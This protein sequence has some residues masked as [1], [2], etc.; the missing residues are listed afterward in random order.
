MGVW[1]EVNKAN[2]I[3]REKRPAGEKEIE[4]EEGES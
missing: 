4:R 3:V 2:G 1:Y